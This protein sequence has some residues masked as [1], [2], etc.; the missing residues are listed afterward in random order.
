VDIGDVEEVD[1]QIRSRVHDREP[2]GLVAL[3]AKDHRAEAEPAH[4]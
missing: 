2:L 3:A 4:L 1:P